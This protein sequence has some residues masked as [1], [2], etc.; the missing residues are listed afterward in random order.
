MEGTIPQEGPVPHQVLSA[1]HL[2]NF[3]PPSP[4][5]FRVP[6]AQFVN[7]YHEFSDTI[8]HAPPP[9]LEKNLML[10]QEHD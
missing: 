1:Y 10:S 3:S 5:F 2:K 7:Y 6:G 4:K 9:P 8:D